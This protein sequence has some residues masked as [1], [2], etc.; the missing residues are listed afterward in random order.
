MQ[1][2]L[3]ELQTEIDTIA[4]TGLTAQ[5][6]RT[7]GNIT[8]S[9]TTGYADVTNLLLARD[10]GSGNPS[11]PSLPFVAV[12]TGH[13]DSSTAIFIEVDIGTSL[14]NLTFTTYSDAEGTNRI[15]VPFDFIVT[16]WI[17]IAGAPSGKLRYRANFAAFSVEAANHYRVQRNSVVFDSYTLSNLFRVPVAQLQGLIAKA[18][19]GA[20][21]QAELNARLNERVTRLQEHFLESLTITETTAAQLITEASV[22]NTLSVNDADYTALTGSYNWSAGSTYISMPATYHLAQARLASIPADAPL[23]ERDLGPIT[24]AGR[25]VY[26]I[27]PQASWVGNLALIS[28]ASTAGTTITPSSEFKISRNNLDTALAALVLESGTEG[29]SETIEAIGQPPNNSI[30]DFYYLPLSSL[31]QKTLAS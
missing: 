27:Q 23:V 26:E 10:T 28:I 22:S 7:L 11:T 17:S 20:D 15:G 1:A 13:T 16:D 9:M 12:L 31:P 6:E 2:A 19:L 25:R 24:N 8:E 3:D 21:I 18:Q 5:Q 30:N 14:N 29:F 4:P